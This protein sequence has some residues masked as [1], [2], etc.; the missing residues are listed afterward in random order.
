MAFDL[1]K[2]P[3]RRNTLG[4]S[5]LEEKP[6]PIRRRSSLSEPKPRTLADVA[7]LR[8]LATSLRATSK[9]LEAISA[10]RDALHIMRRLHDQDPTT[11]WHELATFLDEHGD[12]LRATNLRPDAC[13]T[14]EESV[15]L[16][17]RLCELD[18]T[19]SRS[20]EP[21]LGLYLHK[22]GGDYR[23]TNHPRRACAAH[24]EAVTLR[25]QLHEKYATEE[26]CA[27]LADSLQSYSAD[28]YELT[29]YSEALAASKE[30]VELRR[31][32]Y[33]A[34]PGVYCAGFA[35][36]LYDHSF[37]LRHAGRF[38]HACVLAQHAAELRRYMYQLNPQT[39]TARADL[40][41]TLTHL[42][43]CLVGAGREADAAVIDKEL[44]A[45]DSVR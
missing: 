22:L 39:K 5:R 29:H 11:H 44:S 37:D 2:Q 9:F 4:V 6:G 3:R 23:A 8:A 38:R 10:E 43:A 12:H 42:S 25:R 17:R 7:S 26:T 35:A 15:S 18:T 21:T 33:T 32:L 31:Q 13:A 27:A 45:V 30:A 20:Y 34:D 14:G 36:A 1:T 40:I 28:L 16:L 24:E 41:R 19:Q